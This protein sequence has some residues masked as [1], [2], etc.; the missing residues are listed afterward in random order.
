MKTKMR[1]QNEL[2]IKVLMRNMIE[3]NKKCGKNE[4]SND[5]WK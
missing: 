2:T 1:M 4:K 5:K 3:R